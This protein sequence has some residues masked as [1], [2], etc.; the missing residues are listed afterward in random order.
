MTV[1]GNWKEPRKCELSCTEAARFEV[2]TDHTN[3]V[4][5]TNLKTG[6]RVQNRG[7]EA[8]QLLAAIQAGAISDDHLAGL[9]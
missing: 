5:I 9:F 4:G 6:R 3:A 1:C 2:E 8:D 7:P